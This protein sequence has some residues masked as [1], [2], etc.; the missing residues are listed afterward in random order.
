MRST[1]TAITGLSAAA[2]LLAGLTSPARAI[3]VVPANCAQAGAPGGVIPGIPVV[4]NW[5]FSEP[6]GSTVAHESIGGAAADDLRVTAPYTGVDFNGT[7]VGFNDHGLL[8]TATQV[9]QP[10]TH[11]FSVC[12]GYQ[13][14]A[15]ETQWNLEQDANSPGSGPSVPGFVKQTGI[16]ARVVG[17]QAD[18]TV[19]CLADGHADVGTGWHTSALVVRPGSSG[20]TYVAC[21]HDGA[22]YSN[23]FVPGGVGNVVPDGVLSVGGK[24]PY[25]DGRPIDPSDMLRGRVAWLKLGR[26]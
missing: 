5:D 16:Y 17:S 21:I 11:A 19:N 22:V 20:G 13:I 4:K 25:P 8:T 9:F 15:G 6:A 23:V 10:G 3:G 2:F 7:S 24:N 14:T 12:I 1:R 26:A 18:Q